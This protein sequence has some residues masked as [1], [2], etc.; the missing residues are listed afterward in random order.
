MTWLWIV[1][2]VMVFLFIFCIFGLIGSIK[3][4]RSQEM[5]A[6]NE[7]VV[8]EQEAQLKQELEKNK[9]VDLSQLPFCVEFKQEFGIDFFEFQK[10]FTEYY[11]F[12]AATKLQNLENLRYDYTVAFSNEYFLVDEKGWSSSLQVLFATPKTDLCIG[13]LQTLTIEEFKKHLFPM[14]KIL[15][16][17]DIN[18]IKEYTTTKTPSKSDVFLTTAFLG[19]TAGLLTAMDS[20]TTTHQYDESAYA[21]VF[22]PETML[23][24]LYIRRNSLS[25]MS[26]IV[27]TQ[28]NINSTQQKIN[29][30]KRERG[31]E[32]CEENVAPVYINL[33]E[34]VL[35]RTREKYQHQL[36]EKIAVTSMTQNSI[37]MKQDQQKDVAKELR[38]LKSLLD[39]EIISQEEFDE[40]KK[41]I[42]GL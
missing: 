14:D 27:K 12:D 6:K 23:P 35:S 34:F 5:I 32:V 1:I 13:L 26:K 19:T 3:R 2:G 7:K 40:K 36:A 25:A 30:L 33:E 24:N 28:N 9:D 4:K 17:E 41:Q 8:Q 18:N 15:Y 37:N 22:T 39:D 20:T 11:K 31:E 38:Q 16:V 29:D 42:L 21:F 10:N